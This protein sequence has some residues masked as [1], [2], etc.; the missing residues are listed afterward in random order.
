MSVTIN[1]MLDAIHEIDHQRR[2][3]ALAR[4]QIDSLKQQRLYLQSVLSK[5]LVWVPEGKF[6]SEALR[7]CDAYD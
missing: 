1:T 6:R 3:L 4:E 5:A 7:A 2:L